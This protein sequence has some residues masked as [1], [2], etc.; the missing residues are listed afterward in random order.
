MEVWKPID[1][2]PGYEVSSMGRV[3]SID[4]TVLDSRGRTYQLRGK[5]L[6]QNK[7]G[8]GYFQVVLSK[9]GVRKNL[10]V[11]RL[12]ALTFIDKHSSGITCHKDGCKENNNLSN[13]RFDTHKGNMADCKL[14]G[15]S[16]TGERNGMSQISEE[17]VVC[18]RK[19]IFYKEKTRKQIALQM[20]ISASQVS[21]IACGKYWA[22]VGGPLSKRIPQSGERSS[23]AKLTQ[24]HV[25]SIRKQYSEGGITQQ[26]LADQYGVSRPS[27][28]LI[29][30]GKNWA[31]SLV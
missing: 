18:I 2:W 30:N 13:L 23:A 21:G 8:S 1:E 17:D 4:R 12:V 31:K 5:L 9:G 24:A 28:S 16:V 7:S 29:V 25:D 14:H 26:A 15:T 6:K 10:S 19:A 27:I 3:R 20:N 22:H 11:H